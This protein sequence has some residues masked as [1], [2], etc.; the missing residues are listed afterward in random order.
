M[1]TRIARHGQA[2]AWGRPRFRLDL[3]A[4]GRGREEG[5]IEEGCPCSACA[6]Y[7]RAYVHHLVRA[8][9]MLAISLLAEHNLTFTAR[10]LARV[11]DAIGAGRLRE[12]R[13]ELLG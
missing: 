2:L 12:L 1:P 7:G 9:E 8:R 10:L 3:G 6:R 5:P 11:R 4:A 13:R